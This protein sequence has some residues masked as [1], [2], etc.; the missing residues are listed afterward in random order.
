[1]I[2]SKAKESPTFSAS[3]GVR[4]YLFLPVLLV[5]CA[6]LTFAFFTSQVWE[7]YYI[8]FRSSRNLVDG[9][10]LVYQP[11]ERVHTFTSPLGVLIPALCYWVSAN[12]TAALWLFRI[13]CAGALGGTA[14]IVA[15]HAQEHRWSKAAL[16]IALCLGLLEAKVIAF[17]ANGMETA[18]LIFFAALVWRELTRPGGPRVLTLGLGYSGLMWT[19]PDACILAAGVT[20]AWWLVGPK[21]LDSTERSWWRTVVLSIAIGSLLYL[22]WFLWAWWYYGSPIPQTVIAKSVYSPEGFTLGRLLASPLRCLVDNTALDGLFLPI[23]YATG[24]WPRDL[25]GFGR[26]LARLSAFLWLIPFI[27][28]PA[29]AASLATLF[30]GMYMH[31]IMPYPWYYGAW[32]LLA[33][34]ALAG[35]AQA[36]AASLSK[37]SL[38]FG[39]IATAC[40]VAG[41]IGI[42]LASSYTCKV[43]Q[44]VIEESG[45]KQI[46]LWLKEHARP[47]DSIFL[48]PIGYIGYFSNLKIFDF[49]GL[50]SPE[51]SNIVREGRGSYANLIG[52]LTPDWIVVRPIEVLDQR[53][54]EDQLTD[55]VL[56]KRWDQREIL[57]AV[58][59]LPG[60][61]WPAFDAQFWIYR[62]RTAQTEPR[63]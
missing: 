42:C 20:L 28:R 26:L 52:E 38:S 12:D 37:L 46:G 4:S 63:N 3:K 9:F 22:P 14:A 23:Y 30:G 56:V 7:D 6:P 31:Q 8:T 62:K 44:A 36:A 11:G 39:R 51:V 15:L 18:L 21:R 16:W 19:R 55:Y 27:P 43:Q 32:T 1:M 58:Q 54:T 48:E 49:P 59:L 45:R 17:A 33:A 2:D 57:D 29:R 53:L 50:T 34:L 47:G 13:I 35:A 61:S 60:R 10:G 5:F 24:G 25:M 40:T 41:S